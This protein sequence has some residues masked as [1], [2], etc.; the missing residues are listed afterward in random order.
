LVEPERGLGPVKDLLSTPFG[1]RFDGLLERLSEHKGLFDIDLRAGRHTS[2]KDFIQKVTQE[3]GDREQ[4]MQEGEVKR[5]LEDEKE[6]R[7][8]KG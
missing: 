6:T 5:Y 8:R 1:I 3:L 4:F 7:D 2:L